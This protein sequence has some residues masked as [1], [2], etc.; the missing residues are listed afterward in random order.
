MG[1]TSEETKAGED[2]KIEGHIKSDPLSYVRWVIFA[3]A[4]VWIGAAGWYVF[5]TRYMET[6]AFGPGPAF[7]QRFAQKV[8]D[9]R[10]SFKQRYDCKSEHLR[11]K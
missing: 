5:G 6:G 7:E 2:V 9:C 3:L 11:V 8:K 4:L 1:E 10:G